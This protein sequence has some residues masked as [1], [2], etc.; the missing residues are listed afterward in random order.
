MPEPL[1]FVSSFSTNAV[2]I[3]DGLGKDDLPTGENLFRQLQA[4]DRNGC[5][6]ERIQISSRGELF[7]FLKAV[8]GRA[9]AGLRPILHFE[10]HGD[11]TIGVGLGD[12]GETAS[13]LEICEYF[14][15]VNVLTKNNLGVVMAACFGLYAIEKISIKEPSPFHFL[16]GSPEEVYD[17]V[18]NAQMKEFYRTMFRTGL[19]EEA[20]KEV[21]ETFQQF[22]VEKHF[23][24]SYGKY[25]RNGLIGTG[26]STR[27]NKIV[28]ET[29]TEKGLPLTE[30]NMAPIRAALERQ[31]KPTAENFKKYADVFMIG[32]YSL[33][34]DKL[35]KW[36]TQSKGVP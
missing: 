33:C 13:W 20:M 36:A 21:D 2:L 12:G 34:Y 8:V 6:C 10:M 26:R 28:E 5:L 17:N 16:I 27:I 22:H 3:L 15:R 1:E 30:Q 18:I 29:L 9:A 19:L 4:M 32:R 24:T 14:Q 35:L 25:I 31:M 7:D 23:A 11:P